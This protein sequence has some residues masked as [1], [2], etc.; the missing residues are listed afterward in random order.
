MTVLTALAVGEAGH[1]LLVLWIHLDPAGQ[2]ESMK[3]F[4]AEAGIS[5]SSGLASEKKTTSAAPVVAKETGLNPQLVVERWGS[6]RRQYYKTVRRGS[7]DFRTIPAQI[8]GERT[9]LRQSQKHYN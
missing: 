8:R 7:A 9:E 5:I 3:E 4:L 2:I 6:A 1:L